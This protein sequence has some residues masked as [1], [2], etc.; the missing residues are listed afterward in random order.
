[1]TQ[2]SS[3]TQPAAGPPVTIKPSEPQ[4]PL[5]KL[6]EVQSLYRLL[7]DQTKR[8]TV[9]HTSDAAPKNMPV[10]TRYEIS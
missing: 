7:G 4:A 1:M 6:L 2:E 3:P 5:S 9:P 8:V 10:E